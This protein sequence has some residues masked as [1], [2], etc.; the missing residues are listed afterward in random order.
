M[1]KSSQPL[2]HMLVAFGYGVTK[3]RN[4]NVKDKYFAVTDN[5]ATTGLSYKPYMR[6]KSFWDLHY[7]LTHE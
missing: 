4:G 1:D 7:G 6:K 2:P 3:K 5:G